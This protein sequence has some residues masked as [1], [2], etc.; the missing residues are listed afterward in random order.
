MDGRSGLCDS[1]RLVL[2]TPSGGEAECGE[3]ECSRWIAGRSDT[4]R[5][6]REC[7]IVDG[8]LGA[9]RDLGIRRDSACLGGDDPGGVR[10]NAG[11]REESNVGTVGRMGECG[12][13]RPSAEGRSAFAPTSR[14]GE[15]SA[16]RSGSSSLKL[17]L[18]SPSPVFP[19]SASRSRSGSGS[20]S[21]TITPFSQPC[22]R[23]GPAPPIACRISLVTLDVEKSNTELSFDGGDRAMLLRD[24]AWRSFGLSVSCSRSGSSSE[25]EV[26]ISC[27]ESRGG[28]CRERPE[29]SASM[30]VERS[31]GAIAGEGEGEVA[32]PVRTSGLAH[33]AELE[34][35]PSEGGGCNETDEPVEDLP[36]ALIERTNDGSVE[37][38]GS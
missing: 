27:E 18:V 10:E 15:R 7:E 8:R 25:G 30:M 38:R 19:L 16:A 14:F 32:K 29:V 37:D 22:V 13:G 28:R 26:S 9:V 4:E 20:W 33:G 11:R 2:G 1:A 23:S 31:V 21:S 6:S 36:S 35:L 24:E 34:C 3:A 5:F 12:A 17:K